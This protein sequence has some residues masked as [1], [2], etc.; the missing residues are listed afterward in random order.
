MFLPAGL[1]HIYLNG[2]YYIWLAPDENKENKSNR[3]TSIQNYLEAKLSEKGH[4][5]KA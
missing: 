3:S 2:I 5:P 1:K 4:H